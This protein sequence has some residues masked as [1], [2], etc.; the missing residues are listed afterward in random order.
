VLAG[1]AGLPSS[2]QMAVLR[3]PEP[4]PLLGLTGCWLRL[5]KSGGC[6]GLGEAFCC[7]VWQSTLCWEPDGVGDTEVVMWLPAHRELKPPQ[8]P[9]ALCRALAIG[10]Y[11]RRRSGLSA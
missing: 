8:L 1:A 10:T 5:G 6:A 2:P 9:S 11:G 4:S 3:L 7:V